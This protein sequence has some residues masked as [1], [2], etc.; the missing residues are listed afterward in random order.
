MMDVSNIENVSL[1]GDNNLLWSAILS[2]IINEVT[3]E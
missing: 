3:S 1:N 2:L